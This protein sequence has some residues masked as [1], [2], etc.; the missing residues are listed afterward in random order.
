MPDVPDAVRDEC[1]REIAASGLTPEA[2]THLTH[3]ALATIDLANLAPVKALLKRF[4]SA[5]RWSVGD[6]DAL[7]DLV[8]PGDG[9]WRHE[10]DARF[11][12][13]FGWREGAVRLQL[14]PPG[15]APAFE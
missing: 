8:G 2:V 9:W 3:D 15:G 5:E 7:A 6:D 11:A 14:S 1:R 13:A 12:F 10:L 4:F